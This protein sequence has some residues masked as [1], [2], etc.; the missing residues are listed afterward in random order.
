MQSAAQPGLKET[1]SPSIF[2]KDISPAGF[3]RALVFLGLLGL[4]LRIGFYVEHVNTPSF[5]VPTLDQK[6]YD[7]V[8]K[9]LLAGEDLHELRGFRPLLYPMFLAFFYKLGGNWG[10]DLALLAQ[11]LLGIATGL[12][13]ALLGA[14]LFRH[15]LAGVVGGA[16]FLLAPLPL[17]CEGELLIEPS[18]T[19]L[20]VLALLLHLHTAAKEGWRGAL[21]WMLCGGLIALA[22]Q[23]RANVLVFLAFYPLFALWRWWHIRGRAALLPLLG[24]AGVLAMMVPWGII[25]LRQADGFHLVTNAGGVALYLGNRRG[26]DGMFAYDVATALSELSVN[27]QI[28]AGAA[29]SE[30]YEDLVEVWAREEYLAAMRAQNREPESDPKAISR[31]WTQRAVD[32][33]KADPAAWLRLIARKCWL[34]FWNKEVPNNKDFAFVAQEHFWLGVLPVRWVVLLMLAPA[35]LWAAARFGIRDHLFILLVYAGSYSA[36]NLAFFICDRYRYP[37]LPVL[38]VLAGGGVLAGLAM[39]RRRRWRGLLCVLAGAGVM[40]AIS[41]PNWFG[42]KLPNF[43]QD[44]YF[45]SCAWYEK[46]RF[47]EALEDV[48]RSVTLDSGRGTVQ[49]HRGNVLFALNRLEE[50]CQA[51]ERTLTLLPGDSGVWNNLGA[52]LEALGKTDAALHAYRR[53]TECRPPIPLAFLGIAFI[54]TRAGQ[55]EDAAAILDQLEKLQPKPSAATLAARATIERRRGDT[56]RAEALEQQARQLDPEATAWAIERATKPPAGN[57]APKVD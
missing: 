44:F 8:A 3:N 39:F 28:A 42:I 49:H 12:L 35:G 36:S 43:A 32:E 13:V 47:T 41:L 26:A 50:A 52:A 4:I 6:Y 11:H 9:M 23:A 37:V 30:R 29:A 55:L 56:Q 40:A 51:Y 48:N 31:Y 25:N 1:A 45:R 15:R 7:T 53:A 18:Y 2:G 14:R 38:A 33:I 19:F 16:L 22:S 5:G 27:R 10:V 57:T 21:L 20:I 24:L 46:G 34:M 17:F 54:Q